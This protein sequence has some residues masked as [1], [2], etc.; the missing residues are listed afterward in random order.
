MGSKRITGTTLQNIRRK[1]FDLHP[2]CV[3]CKAKGKTT[4]ATELDHIIP[5]HQGG[6]DFDEDNGTN[7]QGLCTPCH[8]EKSKRERG[9][10]YKPKRSYGADGWPTD[11]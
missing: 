8:T 6:K 2:L 3:M 9:H 10:R 5:L 4:E 11:R 7:R 1:W